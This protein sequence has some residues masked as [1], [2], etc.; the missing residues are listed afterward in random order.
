MIHDVSDRGT[1]ALGVGSRIKYGTGF[2]L[3]SHSPRCFRMALMT[4][5]SSMKLMIRMVPRH[6]GQVRGS[7]SPIKSGTGSDL[8]DQPG[9]VFPV[10]LRTFIGFQ[11]AGDPVVFGFFSLSPGDHYC[12]THSTGLPPSA[13]SPLSGMWEHPAW[14][15]ATPGHRRPFPRSRLSP[16]KQP[17]R[18]LRDTASVPGRRKPG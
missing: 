7:T 4:S 13:D 1:W 17:L 16:G 5:R 15:P 11:D 18:V 8:L 3:T 12:S 6:F 9:P 10:F 2:D 14:R